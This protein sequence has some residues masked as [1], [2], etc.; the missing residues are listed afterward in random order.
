MYFCVMCLAYNSN[1]NRVLI[2]SLYIHA[3]V[4]VY[5]DLVTLVYV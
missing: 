1:V 3:D 2:S 5:E 4:M